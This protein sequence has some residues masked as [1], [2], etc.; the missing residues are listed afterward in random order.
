M[1]ITLVFPSGW[2]PY[3]P[4]LALPR[5]T[6]YMRERGHEVIQRDLNLETFLTIL[7]PDFLQKS[8][9]KTQNQLTAMPSQAEDSL[10]TLV[11]G[12]D[13]LV[14][15]VEFLTDFVRSDAFYEDPI[16]TV[17][18]VRLL[19]A[20]L[21]LGVAPYHPARYSFNE[22]NLP[23]GATA[24]DVKQAIADEQV[25]FTLTVMRDYFL[26]SI[27]D[28]NPD[29]VGIS[30]SCY[31]QIIPALTLAAL[32]KE[33]SPAMYV[34][35]GGNTATR[36]V[37]G[38]VRNADEFFGLF[39]SLI[40]GEGELALEG[41]TE[42]LESKRK[43]KDVPGLVYRHSDGQIYQ[44]PVELPDLNALPTADFD[45]LLLDKYL[46]PTLMLPVVTSRGCHWGKCVFCERGIA[47]E[48]V[49]QFR[50]DDLVIQ[51]IQTLKDKHQIGYVEFNEDDIPPKRLERIANKLLETN[52]N[53]K[54]FA[55]GRLEKTLTASVAETLYRSGCRA[56]ML[57]LESGNQRILDLMDKDITLAQ[58]KEALRN[59]SEAGIWNECF[60]IVGFP[61]ETYHE[62]QD[63]VDLVTEHKDIIH[64]VSVNT[65]Y[66]AKYSA[67]AER[68]SDFQLQIVEQVGQDFLWSYNYM[69]ESGLSMREASDATDRFWWEMKRVH[70]NLELRTAL[71]WEPFYLF[72]TERGAEFVKSLS[73]VQLFDDK[74]WKTRRLR[75]RPSVTLQKIHDNLVVLNDLAAGK[76][77]ALKPSAC[78]FLELCQAGLTVG[79][80][81][82]QVAQMESLAPEMVE[83]LCRVVLEILTNE[84]SVQWEEMTA[85]VAF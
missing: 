77:F 28:A 75:L 37:D 72:V 12:G 83:K 20:C 65:F 29:L 38:L 36:I 51:D 15:Q 18:N 9:L 2:M 84:G 57:G 30:I 73:L 41:L 76:R 47:G 60:I 80:A 11:A 82:Q 4:Y 40:V 69:P 32:I 23:Y 66:L 81:I 79:Q 27:L 7:Q 61:T 19:N 13:Y 68:P 25:N 8:R 49:Y 45:G 50:K 1:R 14:S 71:A 55:L 52:L 34:V 78:K 48:T 22:L 17:R 64:S 70:P 16:A 44:N 33:R 59:C 21:R 31:Q 85:E 5:L 39:D 58:A 26:D 54:W 53:V 67:M 35:L 63:S 24:H 46:A 6:A 42:A 43:F 10:H 62:F 74:Y 3:A 56:L